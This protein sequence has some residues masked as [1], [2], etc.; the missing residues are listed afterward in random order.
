MTGKYDLYQLH[1]VTEYW[2]VH[3]KEETVMVFK[4]GEDN[5][6]GKPERYAGD[7]MFSVPFFGNLVIDLKSVFSE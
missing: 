3:P 7:D 2:I 4:I 5:M 1:G 6:Y